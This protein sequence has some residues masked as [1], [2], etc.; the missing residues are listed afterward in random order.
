[1]KEINRVYAKLV[2]PTRTEKVPVL[3]L[4]L[5]WWG[6]RELD[7]SKDPKRANPSELIYD[8]SRAICHDFCVNMK[9]KT[10]VVKQIFSPTYDALIF[11]PKR[12]E[13]LMKEHFEPFISVST[14]APDADHLNKL[15]NEKF[16][17]VPGDYPEDEEII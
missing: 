11:N 14:D 16:I 17:K 6:Y 5:I 13:R 9:E 4:F 10:D 8:W 7:C 12:K 2:D 3:A 15:F 1:M